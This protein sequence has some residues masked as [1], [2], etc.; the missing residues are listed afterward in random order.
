MHYQDINAVHK[1]KKLLDI[2]STLPRPELPYLPCIDVFKD[3][4]PEPSG[5]I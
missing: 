1:L 4:A 2:I 5:R 3:C